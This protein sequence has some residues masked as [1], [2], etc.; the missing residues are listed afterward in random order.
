MATKKP[1]PYGAVKFETIDQYHATFPED[2][3][4]LLDE[5][6]ET[7]RK[8][9]PKAEEVISYN[10]PAFKQNS[11]LVYYAAYKNHIGFYPTPGPMVAFKDELEKYQTSKG[12]I[13][14]PIESGIS[15]SLVKKIVKYRI[16]ET[17][18]KAKEK[19]KK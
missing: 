7:I 12:A 4:V 16:E 11:V 19:K 9:A 18:K 13:Q 14:F 17:E 8:A 10:M 15:K 6:R 1:S 3:Q 2:V 5:M